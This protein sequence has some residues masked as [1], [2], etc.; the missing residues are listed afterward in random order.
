MFKD[1][2]LAA[3]A[4]VNQVSIIDQLISPIAGSHLHPAGRCRGNAQSRKIWT[5]PYLSFQESKTTG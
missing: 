1:V 4:S 2:S 3:D 5:R